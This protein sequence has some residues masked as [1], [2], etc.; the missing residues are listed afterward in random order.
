[1]N[2]PK[3]IAYPY[4]TKTTAKDL[5]EKDKESANSLNLPFKQALSIKGRLSDSILDYYYLI[6]FF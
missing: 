1:M 4:H 2:R 3:V 6:F 5:V